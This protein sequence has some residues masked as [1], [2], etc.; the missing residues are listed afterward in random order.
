M[1][2]SHIDIEDITL[3][4]IYEFINH[5]GKKLKPELAYY[6]QLMEKAYE[7]DK[8]PMEFGTKDKILKH[9]V[10]FNG[11]SRHHAAKVYE[12]AMEYFYSNSTI[13]KDA[14]RNRI[15]QRHEDLINMGIEMIEDSKDIF[16]LLKA[17]A[18][19]AKMLNL[20]KPD[21]FQ[22]EDDEFIPPFR[23]LSMD[24]KQLQLPTQVDRDKLK[25]WVDKLPEITERERELIYQ[26]SL[27]KPLKLFPEE[28]EDLR[29]S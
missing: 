26:E 11:L 29:K 21:D 5:R 2:I 6:M 1:N 4:D 16:N 17:N 27:I 24:A 12:D 22:L 25:E 13:T 23:I 15:A 28:N 10:K 18:D 19:L 8:K 20:D 9:F 3:D 7:M 14:H